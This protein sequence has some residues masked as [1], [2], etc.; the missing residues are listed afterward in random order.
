MIMK[1][2]KKRIP[3][4]LSI[5][6]YETKST[7]VGLLY[8]IAP[9][10]KL[11][12]PLPFKHME[13]GVGG[14]TNLCC[15]IRKSPGT[16]NGNNLMEVY[17]SA[18]ARKIR[19]SILD[20]SF[21]YCD[22]YHCPHYTA[23]NLPMQEDCDGSIYEEIIK[24][25]TTKLDYVN[26][27]LSFDNRCNLTCISCR[28]DIV[29]YKENEK[30]QIEIMMEEVKKNLKHIKHLGLNGAGDIFVSPPTRDFLFNF[31]SAEYPDLQ[32]TFLTN[33]LLLDE[34]MWGKMKKAIPAIKSVQV[35]MDG[36]SAESYEQIRRGS[37]FEKLK[38]NLVYLSKLRKEK[39]LNEFISSFVVNAINFREMPEFIRLGKELSCDQ[40]YFSHLVDWGALGDKYSEMAVH[41]PENKHHKEFLSVSDY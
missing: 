24:N 3:P 14:V 13:I 38:S 25:Q 16:V 19:E 8:K 40:V 31:D 33:G 22:L 37:S 32:I 4:W 20:G 28:N 27:W 18:A 5:F 26:L 7:I 34:A 10:R 9:Q 36:A 39:V 41:L 6:I 21:K 30:Q 29:S 1:S 2:I 12:C 35:S 23:G 17:N 15:Y 11:F